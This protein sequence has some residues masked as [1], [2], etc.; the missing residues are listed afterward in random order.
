MATD[1]GT[2]YIVPLYISKCLGGGRG[3]FEDGAEDD[4]CAVGYTSGDTSGEVVDGGAGLR[5]SGKAGAVLE[6]F[7]GVDGHDGERQFRLELME[8]RFACAGRQSGDGTLDDTADGVALALVVSDGL[9]ETCGVGL[10]A[11]LD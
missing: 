4:R 5:D 3:G 7:A 9:S 8:E 11:Y 10:T 2:W 1:L 6:A